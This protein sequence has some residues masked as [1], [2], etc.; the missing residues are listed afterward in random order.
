MGLGKKNIRLGLGLGHK[1]NYRVKMGVKTVRPSGISICC[2]SLSFSETT[3]AGVRVRVFFRFPRL[4]L[5]IGYSI[6]WSC[7][8]RLGF[9]TMRPVFCG[10][11]DQ[12]TRQSDLDRLFSKYGRVDRV[13]MKSGIFSFFFLLWSLFL[14]LGFVSSLSEWNFFFIPLK[15]QVLH[16][17]RISPWWVFMDLFRSFLSLGLLF[18]C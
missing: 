14:F 10:N 13:D 8:F 4:F 3:E 16:V 5:V 7:C 6:L 2:D 15:F 9:A 12:D 11:F 1:N 18:F 17:N